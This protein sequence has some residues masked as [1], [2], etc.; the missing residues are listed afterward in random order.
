MSVTGEEILAVASREIG[1]REGK[2]TRTKYGE[3]YG[4][5]G[6]PW[7]MEFVQ[8][9]YHTAGMDLPI[10]TAGC[11]TLLRWYKRNQ[12]D[13]ITNRPIQGSIAIFDLPNT[14]SETD[15]TGLFVKFDGQYIVTID[16]N[17]SNESEGN[18]G[19]VQQRRRK[20]SYAN[21]I[22]II[23]RG[24]VLVD[25][26]KAIAEMTDEQAYKLYAKAERHMATLPL[27]TS[28]D[29]SGELSKAVK[30]G[31]TDGSRPQVPARRYEAAIMCERAVR[32]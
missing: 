30:A 32:K 23:P 18:G 16:G 27:P 24:L 19:W 31:I 1:Y 12:P 4:L 10:K 29:A 6:K 7:C 9:V 20:L 13:C 11:G 14:G 2:G 8:W 28:W 26:D 5:Q 21:P 17:T 15:H 3:W 22:Y 25:W